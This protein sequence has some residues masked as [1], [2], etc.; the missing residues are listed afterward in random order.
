[1]YSRGRVSRSVARSL[2]ALSLAALLLA[3]P[4]SA[5]AAP[6][7]KE[8]ESLIESVIAA[9]YAAGKH[10]DALAQL[11]LGKQACANKASCSAKVRGKLYVAIGTVLAGGKKKPDEAK[12]AFQTALKEDPSASLLPNATSPEIQKAFEEA[13]GG[14]SGA[15][16]EPKKGPDTPAPPPPAAQK[17]GPKKQYPGNLRPGRGWRNAE[18]W[19]YHEEA[20][21]SEQS[22]DWV[23]CADYAQASLAAENR[24]STRYLAATCAER[25]GLWIEAIADYQQVAEGAGKV[26]L[27]DVEG[28]AKKALQALRDKIPKI[29]IRKPARAESLV[30]KMN[31]VEVPAEKLGGEIWVNPGQRTITARGTVDGV[32]LEFEQVVE[33]GES[34]TTSVDIKLQPKGAKKDQAMMRCMLAA[35]TRDDFAKCLNSGAT[36]SLNVHMGI[37]VGGYHDSQAVDVITPAYFASIESP[38]GGWGVSASILVDVVTAASA[39]IVATASQRWR[40][41]RYVPSVGGHKKFGDVDLSLRGTVSKEPDYL[42]TTVG[43]GIS[44]DLR[45]KTITPSLHYD[46]SYDLNGRAGSALSTFKPI[47]R[48]GIEASTTFVLD[49]ATLFAATFTAVIESGDSSKPYRYIPMFTQDIAER[50]PAGLAIDAVNEVRE[51]VRVLEQLPKSRQRYA[52]AGLI[53]HRFSSSTIRAEERL[54]IDNWG[55]KAST[56][57]LQYLIDVHERVRIW[58][59]VRANFQT[60]ASFWQLAYQMKYDKTGAGFTVPAIRTGDRE[61]G[62]LLG[63]TF[64][65]G[66]RF[67]LGEK[68]NWALGITGNVNY[69]RFLDHLFLIDRLAYFGATTV[70]VD[71]E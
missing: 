23:D 51:P 38:T 18:A 4:R 16:A 61:L 41:V 27:H 64:G 19:F 54:Y 59:A 17:R 46:F 26:G 12:A 7:D 15:A 49:K 10:D 33:A 44:V 20:V 67:A 37:E 56:T 45:Q 42:A 58:P 43:T 47:M 32:P 57:A 9:D 63:L 39:D 50:V 62:P 65:A 1:M 69:T 11:E 53:A 2:A 30:V 21:K 28:R 8:V 48:H 60:A 34:E 22:R 71:F 66:A 24:V 5:L 70:E 36:A 52:L 55:L 68:K 3:A 25:G 29:V 40:E 31:D 6:N 14:S 35:Q 13:K